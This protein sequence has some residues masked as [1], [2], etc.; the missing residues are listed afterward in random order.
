MVAYKN[1]QWCV[2]LRYYCEHYRVP[3]LC[4]HHEL[5]P[6][7]EKKPHDQEEKLEHFFAV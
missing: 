2:G 6:V 5:L 4:F 7:R 1:D 3:L